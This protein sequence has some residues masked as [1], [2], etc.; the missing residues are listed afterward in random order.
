[1]MVAAGRPVLTVV[2]LLEASTS[3]WWSPSGDLQ[4]FFVLSSKDAPDI[5]VSNQ[6][7]RSVFHVDFTSSELTGEVQP[8]T[9][10]GITWLSYP[11]MTLRSVKLP[12]TAY[13]K[14]H[15]RNFQKQQKSPSRNFRENEM[16]SASVL[17]TP[18]KG[19]KRFLHLTNGQRHKFSETLETSRDTNGAPKL[20][21]W[22]VR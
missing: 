10:H 6:H 7:M 4:P 13:Q 15:T 20:I 19:A 9:C 5:F 2:K 3:N 14:F 21:F 18:L 1:M 16:L 17:Y 8:T 22:I 11:A 12:E